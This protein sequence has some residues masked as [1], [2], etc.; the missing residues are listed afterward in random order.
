MLFLC[1][2]IRFNLYSVLTGKRLAK[3]QTITIKCQKQI[4]VSEVEAMGMTK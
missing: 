4:I 1:T 3:D 2:F